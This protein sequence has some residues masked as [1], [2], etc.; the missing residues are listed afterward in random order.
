MDGISR[1]DV[2]QGEVGDCWFVSALATLTT[3]DYKLDTVLCDDN[4]Y[5]ENYAGIFHFR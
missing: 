5:E 3:H 2:E 4:S 1:F